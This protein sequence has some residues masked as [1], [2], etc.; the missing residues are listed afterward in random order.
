MKN[1]W[2]M[3]PLDIYEAHMKLSGISQM[4]ALG[5]VMKAQLRDYPFKTVAIL[6]IAGGNGLEHI[7]STVEKV[8]GIDI[9]KDYINI[10]KKRYAYLGKRLELIC[11]D[12]SHIEKLPPCELVLA[13]LIVE[14]TG[15]QT[16]TNLICVSVPCCVS[17]V[18]QYSAETDFV[19]VSPYTNAF[20]RIA[21]IHE[22]IDK[23]TL[24][25]A[26]DRIGF[27]KTHEES[28]ALPG[29]KALTRLDYLD[30]KDV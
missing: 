22:D 11:T 19:S 18:I 29:S 10:C 7:G 21:A 6:G 1:P 25:K 20:E 9:N 8:Y 24:T 27:R 3:L 12:L 13:N 4:Q 28:I 16:F 14:Y 15:M 2:E 23:D 17:C 30:Y 5:A 26:M